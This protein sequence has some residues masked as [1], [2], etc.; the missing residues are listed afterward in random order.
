MQSAHSPFFLALTFLIFIFIGEHLSKIGAVKSASRPVRTPYRERQ[1][2]PL[3]PWSPSRSPEPPLAL[4][5]C[6]IM[7]LV[8]YRSSLC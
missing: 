5:R 8:S 1:T 7:F 4:S 2:P 3:L 6:L